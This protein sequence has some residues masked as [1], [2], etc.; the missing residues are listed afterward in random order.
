MSTSDDESAGNA[1]RPHHLAIA[2]GLGIALFTALS[3]IVPLITDWHNENA[4]HREVFE[5]GMAP[6]MGIGASV[7]VRVD[8][9][10]PTLM[11]ID[12]QPR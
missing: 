12:W 8:A 9:N 11:A 6:R 1:F 7:G 4:I 5:M 2:L 3:R 10:D